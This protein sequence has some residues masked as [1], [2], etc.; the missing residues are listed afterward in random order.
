VLERVSPVIRDL[1]GNALSWSGW[2]DPGRRAR[3]RLTVA[4]FH[5]VL[6]GSLRAAYPLPGLVV[7]PDELAWFLRFFV[8]HYTVGTLA[9]TWERWSRGEQPERPFL[10]LTFDDG[11]RD[12]Y[13]YARHVLRQFGVHATFFATAG[14]LGSERLLW[15]DRLGFAVHRAGTRER[16]RILDRLGIDERGSV[17][18]LGRAAVAHAK[19]LEAEDR[20]QLVDEAESLAGGAAP[21]WAA[22]MSWSE[23]QQLAREH[24]I[25]SH[26]MSHALLPGCSDSQLEE[27]VAGSRRVLEERLGAPVLTFCYPNGDHDRRSVAAVRRAGYRAAVTVAWGSNSHRVPAHTLR[28]CDMH[29]D[30]ARHRHGSMSTARLAWRLSGWY[31]GLR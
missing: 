20:A 21:E 11:Q 5:R 10:A 24:E 6:P 12:N 25:G 17:L 4:T 14:Y 29:P 13:Q 18:A 7:T 28:R 23:L 27:E 31:P 16:R 9:D 3:G 1:A 15:H 19:Q 26:T 2:T 22:L 8:A 30:H